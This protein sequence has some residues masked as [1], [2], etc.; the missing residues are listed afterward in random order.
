M[1]S[2]LLDQ[3]LLLVKDTVAILS[4]VLRSP[5]AA[6]RFQPAT[7][8]VTPDLMYQYRAKA[9]HADQPPPPT[10]LSQRFV[11]LLSLF[12]VLTVLVGVCYVLLAIFLQDP[13]ES[14][15][16]VISTFGHLLDSGVS[17]ILGISLGKAAD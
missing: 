8:S 7:G 3:I 14:Q 4:A 17:A 9:K 1:I 12:I 10:E 2:F 13:N 11:L 15:K 6:T 5:F 16:E